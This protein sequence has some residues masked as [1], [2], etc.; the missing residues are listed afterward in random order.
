MRDHRVEKAN[1]LFNLGLCKY[2]FLLFVNILHFPKLV[3]YFFGVQ[4]L[5]FGFTIRDQRE[6]WLYWKAV[7]KQLWQMVPTLSSLKGFTRTH[8][9]RT[10]LF[11][12]IRST[13]T[14]MQR[15]FCRGINLKAQCFIFVSMNI[16]W[17]KKAMAIVLLGQR[18]CFKNRRINLWRQHMSSTAQNRENYVKVILKIALLFTQKIF[19][20]QV[21]P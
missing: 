20:P 7:L 2:A 11:M 10:S 17:K 4:Y 14:P 3:S 19:R 8:G 12:A 13:S 6:K 5:S 15:Y 9:W 18:L 1:G 21:Y 16:S